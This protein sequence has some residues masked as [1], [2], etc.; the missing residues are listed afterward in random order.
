MF[1]KIGYAGLIL[2]GCIAAVSVHAAENFVYGSYVP[3]SHTFHVDGLEPYFE[4]LEEQS[5]GELQFRLLSDGTMVGS[6][7]TLTGIRNGTVDMGLVVDVYIPSTLPTEATLNELALFADNEVSAAAAMTETVLLHCPQCLEE[8]KQAGAKPIAFYSTSP[9]YLMCNSAVSDLASIRGKR[10]KSATA[11]NGLA[12]HFGAT[13]VS[14]ATSETYEAL[15]RGQADCAFAG[16]AYL[17]SYGLADVVDYIVDMPMGTF[18]G[19]SFIN[20]NTQRWQALTPEQRELFK[21]NAAQAI[22]NVSRGYANDAAEAFETARN[23]GVT[24][25]EPGEPLKTSYDKYLAKERERVAALAEKRGVNNPEQ[26]VD[27]YLTRL[28]KWERIVEK[29][30]GDNEKLVE[31][32]NER[33]YSKVEF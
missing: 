26:L 10:I 27:D 13:P 20:M 4:A 12:A 24:F 5:D 3:R 22:V 8:W 9:Y 1:T 33:I 6:S 11:W 2:V 14:I 28:D 23:S 19:A 21:R 32:I 15:S 18:M 29:A 17:K 25:V 16:A 7:N 31:A 30:D